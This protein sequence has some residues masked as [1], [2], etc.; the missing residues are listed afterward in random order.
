MTDSPSRVELLFVYNADSGL[1]NTVADAA[2]KIL[3]P[4]TY[5]CN[6]CKVTYGWFTERS[7]W[8]R[9]VESLDVQCSFLHRDELQRRHPEL[10][11]E[12]LPAVFRVVDGKAARCVDAEHPER[13]RRSRRADRVD[14]RTLLRHIQHRFGLAHPDHARAH[15]RLG[16]SD[17]RT[18]GHSTIRQREPSSP[19]D[20][21]HRDPETTTGLQ[22]PLWVSAD[23]EFR[24]PA[25]PL[26]PLQSLTSRPSQL[27]L[28]L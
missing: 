21:R 10:S 11:G 7:Q 5:S 15:R 20:I 1:F 12:P 18:S 27:S 25:R 17:F 23:T 4:S 6:L 13:L 16:L 2:H 28:P 24:I 19:V 22:C 8:R 9:F 14:P 26:N 3:S